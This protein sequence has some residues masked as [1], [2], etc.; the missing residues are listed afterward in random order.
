[1]AKVLVNKLRPLLRYLIT[2]LQSSFVPERSTKDNAIMLQ[3]VIHHVRNSSKKD[4][5][6]VLKLDL[7]K[8]YNRIDWGCLKQTLRLY[9]LSKVIVL[10]RMHRISST[11]ISLLWNGSRLDSFSPT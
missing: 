2:P 7:E 11:N 6:I 10:L 4:G 3:E 9:G 8:A 5:D 1:V